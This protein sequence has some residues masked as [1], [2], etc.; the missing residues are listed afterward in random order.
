MTLADTVNSRQNSA[1]VTK[2]MVS[3]MGSNYK[4]VFSPIRIRGIDFKNRIT[5]APPSPNLASPDGL[6]TNEFLDWMRMFARGGATVL[7]VGNS[8]IDI[9]ECK[10]EECQL[11]LN[12]PH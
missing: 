7:Y 8:S 3:A 10:D 6:V 1:A 9:T 4:H 11:D 5:L 2:G 12:N